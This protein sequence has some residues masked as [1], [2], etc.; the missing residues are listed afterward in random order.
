MDHLEFPLLWPAPPNP[1]GHNTVFNIV[2]IKVI[3][4]CLVVSVLGKIV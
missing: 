4:L 1:T 2:D 3:R